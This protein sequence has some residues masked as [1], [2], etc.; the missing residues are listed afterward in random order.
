VNALPS[1]WT[2]RAATF[3]VWLLAAASCAYWGLKLTARPAGNIAAP[4]A[5]RPPPAIDP[6]AVARLLGGTAPAP[7]AVAAQPSLASRFALVGV[8]AGAQSRQGAAVIAVDGKPA[9]PF[10]VGSAVDEGLVVLAV[11]G[12]QAVLGPP[13]GAPVLTLELPPRK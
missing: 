11:Q 3:A 5:V 12:R 1:P 6:A 4:V 7:G 2:V 13:G 9:R 8:V 10:R